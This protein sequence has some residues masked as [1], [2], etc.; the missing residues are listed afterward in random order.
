MINSARTSG[1]EFILSTA[2]I[3]WTICINC[4]AIASRSFL[5]IANSITLH[6]ECNGSIIRFLKLH[7]RINLQFAENSSIK[8]RNAGC[9]DCGLR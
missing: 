3:C 8:P 7:V 6:L 4:P 1:S 5:G 2:N 9:V